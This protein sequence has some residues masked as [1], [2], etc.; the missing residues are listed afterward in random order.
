M[1]PQ[2]GVDHFK[3][4]FQR[5]CPVP[6][7]PLFH[8]FYL[9]S[10]LLPARFYPTTVKLLPSVH[11]A[12]KRETNE[13]KGVWFPLSPSFPVLPGKP[14][15]FQYLCPFLCQFQPILPKAFFQPLF[16]YFRLILVLETAY[17][18]IAVSY[19]ITFSPALPLYDHIKPV[20]QHI[21]QIDI[22]KYWTGSVSLRGSPFTVKI[23]AILHD[24]RFQKLL[25][26]FKKFPVCYVMG[27]HLHQPFMVYIIKESP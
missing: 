20:I 24:S 21:M 9:A 14:P 8:R 18:V 11:S 15:K 1:S 27:Q 7:D 13:V 3:Q 5:L 12:I 10:E 16:K 23:P 26:D 22:R 2:F 19:E 25:D 6:L 17:K 4:P